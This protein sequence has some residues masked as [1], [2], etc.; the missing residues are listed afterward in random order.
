V[1]ATDLRIYRCDASGCNGCD[2]AILE[3][4]TVRPLDRLGLAFAVTPEDAD[5][6]LV[7]G[8]ANLKAAEELRGIVA[9]MPAG[10]RVIAVGACAASLGVFKGGY[11]MAGP[12]DRL[13]PVDAYVLGCPP[14]P[15]ALLAAL[16]GALA[17]P[18]EDADDL[19]PP[20][21][22]RG[23]AR[24]DPATC[25][26][27]AACA[28]VCPADAV[29]IADG[30]RERQVR[31]K[32]A[33]CIACGT[34]QDVCPA[35]AIAVGPGSPTWCTDKDA[36]VSTAALPLATCRACGSPFLPGRQLEWALHR[37]EETE[38]ELRP[39]R[40]R[41]A[42]RLA[43]C[44]TCRRSRIGEVRPGQALLASLP[45]SAPAAD[46]AE[47]TSVVVFEPARC[48]ACRY[49][50]VAC[51]VWHCGRLDVARARLG[52][53]AEVDGSGLQCAAVQCRHCDVPICAAACPTGALT[54][55]ARTGWVT[56]N[57]SRCIGCEM[58]VAACPVAVPAIDAE[59]RVAVKCDMCHGDPQCA[60][61]CSSGALRVVPRA[62]AARLSRQL[63]LGVGG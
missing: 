16:T 36:A 42:D 57:A 29:E 44:P 34:C 9:R 18:A 21:G 58:C 54:K 35:E 48:T 24:V 13:V 28:H 30:G 56:G 3:M 2:V 23:P 46:A 40:D 61:H 6:L 39:F 38:Q 32:Q 26:G 12:V 5:I 20:P 45:E 1:Q 27:C 22:H 25:I 47:P 63:Y 62:E 41:I 60:R 59:Q 4:P 50:E 7:T 33:D 19:S 8:G 11:P 10:R 51:A 14:R 37:I 49:C 43:T 31:F 55:D 53:L 15:H 52:V 17:L